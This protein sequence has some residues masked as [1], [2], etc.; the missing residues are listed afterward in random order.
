MASTQIAPVAPAERIELLDVLRG[1][2]L[3]GV[4]I[5]NLLWVVTYESV[6]REQMAALPTAAID[7]VTSYLVHFFI[8]W[9]FYTLFSF[10]FGLGF[11]VQMSRAAE[12]GGDARRTYLRRLAI[13]LVFGLAHAF[14][15]WYGDILSIYALLGFLLFFCRRISTRKL[16]VL[17]ALLILLPQT[18]LRTL[19]YIAGSG[20]VSAAEQ[21]AE[22]AEERALRE[23]RFRVYTYGAYPEV[24]R[25]HVAFYFSGWGLLLY[26][27]TAIL[28]KFLLGMLAGRLRL[29][30]DPERHRQ[31]F[32]KLLWWGLAVGV[33]GN[34]VFVL[35]ES[36][37][38]NTAMDDSAAS[39]LATL[40][41]VDLGLVGLA[42]F[43][44]AAIAL[45]FQ[46]PAWRARLALLA[47][48]GRMALTN[49]LAH[50]LIYAFLFYGYGIG[51]GLLGKV[52]AA[53]CALLGFLVYTAQIIVSRWWLSRFAF[54]PMEW[55]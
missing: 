1:F 48:L 42:A 51:L 9:K 3:F 25:E 12:R 2:A 49:Y 47:P 41:I 6:T 4:L 7:R 52:G 33:V 26:F 30:H 16:L 36:L 44:A 54:G 39:I 23:H 45:L 5:A 32:R 18:L 13:L 11:S 46:R 38:R 10:L 15:L 17:S 24:V 40:W 28:G 29:F 50:S 22:E 20:Q 53:A 55:L 34:S 43:Y 14:L 31:F 8:D 37:S 19:P 21:T 27:N 35:H